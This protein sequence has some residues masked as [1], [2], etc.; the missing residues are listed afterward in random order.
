MKWWIIGK[1]GLLARALQ[2][3][4][5]AQA[6]DYVAT[7]AEE[8]DILDPLSVAQAAWQIHPTHVINTAAYTDV[9]G[10]ERH[11]ADTFAL[12]ANGAET[13]AHAAQKIGAKLIHISTDYVFDGRRSIPYLEGD[14]CAPVNVYG[15]SKLEGERR[16]LAVCPQSCV[17]RTS[18]LFDKERG[19]IARLYRLLQEGKEVEVVQD[20][21]GA[22]TFIED[23][24]E[25]VHGLL[26]AEGIVHFSNR[27]GASRYQ[28]ACDLKH[29]LDSPAVIKP[30]SSSQF[31][32]A[33]TRPA[34]S[35]L[36]TDHYTQLTG[37][38]VRSWKEAFIQGILCDGL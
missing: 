1:K 30:V 38:P 36:S 16:V 6:I 34:Y 14:L 13:V 32:Q 5:H 3:R 20:Q 35:M 21:V 9:D 31:P 18:W 4:A 23:A 19:F 28:I 25:A 37:Q 33:A 29:L 7:S 10:A 12:N 11:L 15:R 26:E 24:T 17:M 22:P 27:E 8:V 2:R